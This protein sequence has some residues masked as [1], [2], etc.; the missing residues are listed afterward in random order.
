LSGHCPARDCPVPWSSQT[1]NFRQTSEL[2]FSN[3]SSLELLSAAP[4]V[5]VHLLL[6]LLP[7]R[8]RGARQA[9]A[10]LYSSRPLGD[11]YDRLLRLTDDVE[12]AD[13]GAW[14]A[15]DRVT[16]VRGEL[17]G[18]SEPARREP[19]TS[20]STSKPWDPTCHRWRSR[21]Q[22]GPSHQLQPLGQGTRG[23]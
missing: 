9:R 17:S 1:Q 13:A 6:L 5:V 15:R 3:L 12:P 2:E 8:G 18:C 20:C 19:R 10:R 21:K 23:S 4:P 7:W 14:P 16:R 22:I 11:A